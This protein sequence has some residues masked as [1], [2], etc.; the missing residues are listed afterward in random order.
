MNALEK[1]RIKTVLKYTWP[2]YI[3]SGIVIALVLNVIF[4]VSHPVPA[5]QTLTLFVT[6]EVTNRKGFN[7]YLLNKFVDKKLRT[8]T[9]IEAT[10][11]DTNYNTKLSVAGYNTADILIIPSA[12]LDNIVVSSFGL[13]LSEE[14]YAS[15]QTYKQDNINYGI[16]IDDDIV[17]DY[18]SIESQDC[19]MILNAKSANIGKYSYDQN[20]DHDIALTLIKE[21]GKNV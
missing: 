3:V 5:Y 17:K 8:V 21:W 18:M 10:T 15:Y 16:K 12:K 20:I 4:K 14:I 11:N 6:G 7:D 9:C 1:G 2:F 19:Y 13:E